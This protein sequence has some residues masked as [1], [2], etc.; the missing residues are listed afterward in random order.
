MN[1][2]AEPQ[3]NAEQLATVLE[4][5]TDY[6]SDGDIRAHVRQVARALRGDGL[7][8]LNGPPQERL[9]SGGAET[10]RRQA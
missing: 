4:Q 8:I 10:P 1:I 6:S 5:I 2:M 9:R 3:P 7:V